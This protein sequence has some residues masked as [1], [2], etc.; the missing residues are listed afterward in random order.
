MSEEVE[1]PTNPDLA[2]ELD[3]FNDRQRA[4]DFVS[5][6]E[7]TMCV[8]SASVQQLYTNYEVFFPKKSER[9]VIL[10]DQAAYHD[11]FFHINTS[12]VLATGLYI[13]PGELIEKTGLFLAN[14]SGGRDLGKRQIPFE[15]GMRAIIANRPADDPFLPVLA[16]GDLRELQE[17][18]PVMHLHRV[19][20]K[21][22]EDISELDRSSLGNVIGEK[23]ESLFVAQQ[24]AS[25]A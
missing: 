10:P 2:W 21:A 17:S 22:L 18:W 19:K 9:I 8:Y 7:S 12:S 11:T 5:Q 16:K 15:A 25:F 20:P 4:M 13:I 6:F 1:L 23:L 24:K 3:D 14:I